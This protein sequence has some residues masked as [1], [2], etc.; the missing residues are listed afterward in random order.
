[1]KYI[2]ELDSFRAIAVLFV[3]IGHGAGVNNYLSKVFNADFGVNLFF[4]LS[5]FLITWILL[6]NREE[7][8]SAGLSVAS[9]FKMFYIRRTLR[10]FPLYYLCVVIFFL[11]SSILTDNNRFIFPWLFTYSAN[12]YFIIHQTWVGHISHV[13]SLAV[14]EQFY[15][16]WPTVMLLVSRKLL[17]L[18][19]FIF[20]MVGLLFYFHWSSLYQL[21]Y[22]NMF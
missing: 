1:M 8:K 16:I 9:I 10:I 13:W 18:A 20:I 17:P 7:A 19:I 4:V 21:L 3:I 11:L 22:Y 12:W 15:L 5:G 2:K 14:E 6:V